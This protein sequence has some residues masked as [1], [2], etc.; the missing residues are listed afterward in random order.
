LRKISYG[1]FSISALLKPDF[2]K[3]AYVSTGGEANIGYLEFL[4]FNVFELVCYHSVV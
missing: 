4:N 1:F 2:P 3:V